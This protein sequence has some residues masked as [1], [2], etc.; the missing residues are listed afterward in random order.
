MNLHIPFIPVCIL[1]GFTAEGTTGFNFDCLMFKPGKEP[2]SV[3]AFALDGHSIL[4]FYF[5]SGLGGGE[6]FEPFSVNLNEVV[7]TSKF[8]KRSNP[9]M[10]ILFSD[11]SDELEITTDFGISLTAKKRGGVVDTDPMWDAIQK[12]SEKSLPYDGNLF[13]VPWKAYK[14]FFFDKYYP[15]VTPIFERYGEMTLVRYPVESVDFP[16]PAQGICMQMGIVCSEN[17]RSDYSTEPKPY[18]V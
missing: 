16:Y 3:R 10:D 17:D 4:E 2:G 5:H 13:S 6:R 11:S 1:S 7:K 18:W 8:N 14:N 9:Y 15:K 12:N